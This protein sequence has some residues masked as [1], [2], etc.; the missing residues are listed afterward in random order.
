MRAHAF[1]LTPGADLKAELARLTEA[2]ELRAGCIVTCVGSLSRARLRMP[3][4]VGE[5]EMVTA[6]EEPM[7]I[8]SLSGTLCA[9]G[10]HV[11]IGLSR[12]D[13]SCVGGHLVE[14]CIVNT[15]AELV[16]GEL[17]EVEFH[18]PRDGATGYNELSVQPRR[19]EGDP[20]AAQ[21]ASSAES[22]VDAGARY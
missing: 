22:A 9:D 10:L 14:G 11:H 8:V 19:S 12:R 1:R 21:P 20:S 16:I 4:A 5:A 7:E 15:T 3:G 2:L 13:G 17:P 18:R 6:F